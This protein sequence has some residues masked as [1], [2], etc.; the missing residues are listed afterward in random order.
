MV[1]RINEQSKV[2]KSLY[3]V[4]RIFEEGAANTTLNIFAY[5]N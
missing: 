4:D 1:T 2:E 3:S 5:K